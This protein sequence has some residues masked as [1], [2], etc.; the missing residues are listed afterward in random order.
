MWFLY[1]QD[2]LLPVVRWFGYRFLLTLDVF[3]IANDTNL[4]CQLLKSGS[5]ATF[6]YNY[7]DSPFPKNIHQSFSCS[8][9]FF[10]GSPRQK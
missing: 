3:L 2:G 6:G 1:G 9:E 8:Q 4:R 7:C 10:Y 5:T